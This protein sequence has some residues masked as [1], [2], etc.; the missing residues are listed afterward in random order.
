MSSPQHINSAAPFANTWF[1]YH[2]KG[3]CVI[4]LPERRK[5]FPPD[6]VT[7]RNGRFSTEEDY[8][9]W[10]KPDGVAVSGGQ[11]WSTAKA[12]IAIRAGNTVT[13]D[14]NDYEI[15][16]IDVDAYAEKHGAEHLRELESTYGPL[17]NTWTSS[18]RKDGVS[19]IRWYLAPQGYEYMGKP[20][21]ANG[22]A[23]DSIEIVQRVHRYGLVFP[24]YHPE[25]K[26]QYWW[27]ATGQSPDGVHTSST[28]PRATQLAILPDSWFQFLTRQGTESTGSV[29]IDMDTPYKQLQEWASKKFVKNREKP[30]RTTKVALKNHLEK[31]EN[32]SDH[33]DPLVAMHW[34][35]FNLGVEGHS[36]W[37]EAIRK[38]EK[39]W[40]ARVAEDN[41]RSLGEAKAEVLRSREGT[42]RKIKGK[43]DEYKALGVTYLMGSDPCGRD[44]KD[45]PTMILP[46]QAVPTAALPDYERNE[47]GNAQNMLDL[48]AGNIRY[49]PNF[50]GM[51]ARWIVFDQ[52]RKRWVVDEKDVE[53]R[54]M[55]R[56]VKT[57]QMRVAEIRLAQANAVVAQAGGSQQANA[58]QKQAVA[59][60]KEWVKWANESGN[61]ARVTNSLAQATTF[62]DVALDFSELDADDMLLPVANGV[63]RFST[64]EQRLAGGN[65]YEWIRDPDQIKTLLVTHNTGVPYIPYGDQ[66]THED[67]EVRDNFEKFDSYMRTFLRD[68][69]EEESFK[70]ALKLLGLSILGVPVKKA[71]F[72]VG[73][74][75]TGKS[76]FQG[77]MN[78]ALGQLSIWRDPSIFIDSN[79]KSALAEALP[80]RVVMV[81]EL[82]EK[83][84]DASLFKRITGGDEVMCELK[85]INQPVTMRARCT[86]ISGCNSAPDVPNVDDATKE[87]FVVIPFNHQVTRQEKDPN[88]Q[89]DLQRHCKVPL[90]AML[91]EACEEAIMEGVQEIPPELQ[92]ATNV[93]V[94]TL[95]EMSDF[96]NDCLVQSPPDDWE[97]YARKDTVDPRDPKPKWPNELCVGHKDLYQ[98]YINY[99]TRNRMDLMSANKFG[100]RMK[101]AGLQQDGSRNADNQSRWLGVTLK[102]N[103]RLHT[104]DDHE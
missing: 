23:S 14:G 68:H 65:P 98:A 41:V 16:G 86:I 75:D 40:L 84:M 4:P 20:R 6:D 73:P 48:Y 90:L 51:G 82:G 49:V 46:T 80:R 71:V 15:V 99:A 103:S 85:N 70:Y 81:G 26:T 5:K 79:F 87:R 1:E 37:L 55:Y 31:I 47:D 29:P 52:T 94:S 9:E 35:L 7:G 57:E 72:L 74:R 17:P 2:S 45:P 13:Q 56:R 53:V 27:Y 101:E 3:W 76:T 12:N 34:N 97:K 93:F 64:R 33:H 102:S 88:A 66:A 44:V 60:A 32:A 24:S 28:I 36:H 54:N 50:A 61:K 100:R 89:E 25:L 78:A 21:L 18:A 91:I 39:V 58:A 69:M 77:M 30:C 42:L 104:A 83:H 96:V 59:D 63:I 92:L 62:S 8:D 11:E 10:S 19:G 22:K 95:S 67:P 38:A 43:D